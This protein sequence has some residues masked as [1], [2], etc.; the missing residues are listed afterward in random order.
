MISKTE[1]PQP[2]VPLGPKPEPELPA[3]PPSPGHIPPGSPPYPPGVL[4]MDPQSKPH[5]GPDFQLERLV[6]VY[7]RMASMIMP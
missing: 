5:P 3:P 6:S 4:P 1:E 7:E 2:G